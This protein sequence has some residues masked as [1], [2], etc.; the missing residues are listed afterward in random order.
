[1]PGVRALAELVVAQ[2]DSAEAGRAQ[3]LRPL[4]WLC[5]LHRRAGVACDGLAGLVPAHSHEEKEFGGD[6]GGH[7]HTH[8]SGTT[9]SGRYKCEEQR[10]D[11]K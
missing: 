11:C 10:N 9:I 5:D 8:S 6:T 2:I 4:C 3:H 1:M 7:T